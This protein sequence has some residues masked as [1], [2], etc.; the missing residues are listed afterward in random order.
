V[1]KKAGVLPYEVTGRKDG[2]P[3]NFSVGPRGRFLGMDD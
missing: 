2:K 1:E 3:F